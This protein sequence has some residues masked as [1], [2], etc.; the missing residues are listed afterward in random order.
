MLMGDWSF[1]AE[2][3]TV[4]MIDGFRM[5][6]MCLVSISKS[7]SKVCED[8]FLPAIPIKRLPTLMISAY[9]N[10]V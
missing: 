9:A 6:V 2:F 7:V 1:S 5:T 10:G 8:G 4:M 3:S